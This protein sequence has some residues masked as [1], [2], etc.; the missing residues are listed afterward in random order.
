[1]TVAIFGGRKRGREEPATGRVSA[2]P[3]DWLVQKL[4]QAFRTCH[5]R[6][7]DQWGNNRSRLVAATDAP[8]FERHRFTHCLKC[9]LRRFGYACEIPKVSCTRPGSLFFCLPPFH[10]VD[11][12]REDLVCTAEIPQVEDLLEI[13]RPETRCVARGSLLPTLP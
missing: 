6:L 11:S 1:M 8:Q 9:W 10:G 13:N 2:R 4:V 7:P 5:H 3:G 12:P